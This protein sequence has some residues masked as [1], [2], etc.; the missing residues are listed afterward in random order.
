MNFLGAQ[1][2][3]F[4]F[5]NLG[6]NVGMKRISI[7]LAL[8]LAGLAASAQDLKP[9]KPTELKEDPGLSVGKVPD[10]KMVLPH[11]IVFSR[12]W[13]QKGIWRRDTDGTETRLS[14]GDDSS[15]A[16]YTDGRIYFTRGSGDQ[17]NIW[18]MK[19][20]GSGERLE[21]SDGYSPQPFAGVVAFIR[22]E[23]GKELGDKEMI[24]LMLKVGDDFRKVVSAVP[25]SG[26]Y[27]MTR[28]VFEP[29]TARL[30]VGT[31]KHNKGRTGHSTVRVHDFDGTGHNYLW[32][33]ASSGVDGLAVY[34][35]GSGIHRLGL[36]SENGVGPDLWK[37]DGGAG[38]AKLIA[39]YGLESS[40]DATS[41]GQLLIGVEG[42][43]YIANKSGSGRVLITG[44]NDGIWLD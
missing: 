23:P 31:H 8:G 12:G 24:W 36:M 42:K 41:T 1:Y 9:A 27:Y 37:L 6:H 38:T 18:S 5:P 39:D 43:L 22:R 21:I 25:A 14:S 10:L 29:G 28:P 2:P 20:D 15:P 34:K 7:L 3:R 30:I 16:S 17:H 11:P 4:R 32:D 44:G 26:V 13:S 33:R 35:D 19:R 40:L